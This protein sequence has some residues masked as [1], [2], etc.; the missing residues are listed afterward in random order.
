MKRDPRRAVVH[1]K[2][3]G[4]LLQ[5]PVLPVTEEEERPVARGK[6]GTSPPYPLRIEVAAGGS[7]GIGRGRRV[8]GVGGAGQSAREEDGKEEELRMRLDEKVYSGSIANVWGCCPF[9]F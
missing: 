5:G 1:P 6:A 2:R 4:D 3:A 9:S 7:L 8:G